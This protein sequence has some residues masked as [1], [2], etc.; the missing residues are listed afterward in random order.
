MKFRNGLID[1]YFFYFLCLLFLEGYKYI[2]CYVIFLVR[3][4]LIFC[5]Y[6]VWIYKDGKEYYVG[7]Y[8]GIEIFKMKDKGNE[9][10][11]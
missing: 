5:C 2:V 10:N 3:Q 4:I 8:G 11:E 6:L 9:R 7:D 1:V